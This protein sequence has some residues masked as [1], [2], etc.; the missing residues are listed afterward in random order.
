MID[1]KA[2]RK[3]DAQEV[4]YA[5][6]EVVETGAAELRAMFDSRVLLMLS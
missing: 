5:C 1:S 6:V 4:I 3:I 2:M